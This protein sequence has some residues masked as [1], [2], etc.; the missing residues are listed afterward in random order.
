MNR[1]LISLTMA[2]LLLCA[3]ALNACGKKE[4]PET[5]QAATEPAATTQAA[6]EELG[7]TTWSLSASTWSSPN[8]ATIHL[9]ATPN[10]HLDGESADFVIR[11][12]DETVET[13][14]CT[15]E[16][17]NYVADADLNTA[18][19]YCYYV[20]LNGADG[21]STE[22]AVNTQIGRAHV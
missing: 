21:T 12:E 13:I 22:V 2:M 4:T 11:L 18:D 17:G 8:G 20:V 1:K 6:L 10:R 9:T 5:T 15:W 19:G 16:D 14:A 7:L 3:M